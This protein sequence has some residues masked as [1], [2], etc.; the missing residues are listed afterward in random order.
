[1]EEENTNMS[2]EFAGRIYSST[3]RT[4]TVSQIPEPAEAMM[5]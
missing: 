4:A 5:L 2:E 1:M 3:T